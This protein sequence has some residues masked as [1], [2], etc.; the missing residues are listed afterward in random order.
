[1]KGG[2][3]AL[4]TWEHLRSMGYDTSITFVGSTPPRQIEQVGVNVIPLLDKNDPEQYRRLWNLYIESHFFLLPTRAEAFGIVFS[5]ASSFGL[6]CISTQTGGVPNAVRNGEN[7]YTL[8]I[9]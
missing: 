2:E 8:P 7:G 3:I 1:R 5:E 4:Q 9:E 6:P